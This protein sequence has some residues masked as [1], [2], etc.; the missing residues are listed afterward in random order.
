MQA[1]PGLAEELPSQLN[2]FQRTPGG[3]DNNDD[4]NDDDDGGMS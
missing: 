1:V 2:V 4:S 3:D